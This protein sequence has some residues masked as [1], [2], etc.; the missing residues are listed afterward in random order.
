ML[1][2]KLEKKNL[3]KKIWEKKF[4]FFFLIDLDPK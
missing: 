3:E 2:S 4:N 1:K